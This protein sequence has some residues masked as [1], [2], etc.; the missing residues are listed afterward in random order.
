MGLRE[1]FDGVERRRGVDR[2][3]IGDVHG[4]FMMMLDDRLA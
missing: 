1:Q 4:L 3:M 2:R